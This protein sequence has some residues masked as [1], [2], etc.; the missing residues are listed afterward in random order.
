MFRSL[1]LF[2]KVNARQ[3]LAPD[4]RVPR[5]ILD[6]I[7][8]YSGSIMGLTSGI[9]DIK[10]IYNY[11]YN[12][13]TNQKDYCSVL[14]GM[15]LEENES[16]FDLHDK[17]QEF[18]REINF[19]IGKKPSSVLFLN[20][21]IVDLNRFCTMDAPSN[22][23]SPLSTDTTYQIAEHYLTQTAYENLSVL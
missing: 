8:E 4:K 3:S 10:Q 23:F 21:T 17:E 19:R 7:E 14:L 1:Q 12:D 9:S 15:C 13:Q 16:S 6:D 11:R 20:Q 2:S 22:Y 5:L 18:I